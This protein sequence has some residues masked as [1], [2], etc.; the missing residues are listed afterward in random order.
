MGYVSSILDKNLEDVGTLQHIMGEALAQ[1]YTLS[2]AADP[3]V[4]KGKE[5]GNEYIKVRLEVQDVKAFDVFHNV[6]FPLPSMDEKQ[7]AAANT[8][9]TE[10]ALCFGVDADFEVEQ[11]EGTKYVIGWK[12][13]AG[14]CIL[15]FIEAGE[16]PAKNEIAKFLTGPTQATQSIY[17]AEELQ[18]A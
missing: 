1:E 7:Q 5:S 14:A 4:V 13:A 18:E 10:F 8:R 12:G 11:T 3:T 6:F 17:G 16:F 2:I 9:L 15:K